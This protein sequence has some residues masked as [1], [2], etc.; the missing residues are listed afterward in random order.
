M[1]EAVNLGTVERER[2]LY[3]IES[4]ALFNNLTHAHTDSLVN[5]NLIKNINEKDGS[6]VPVKDTE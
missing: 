4:T 2:E 5:R 3:F 1:I 6:I